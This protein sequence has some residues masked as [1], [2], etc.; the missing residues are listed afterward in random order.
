MDH[1]PFSADASRQGAAYVVSPAGD[2]DMATVP[3]VREAVQ[4]RDREP[5]TDLLVLDLRRVTFMDTSGLQL[6]VEQL[7]RSEQDGHSFAV[8]RGPRAVQRLLDVAG[9]T[10]ALRMVDSPEEAMADDRDH[11]A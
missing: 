7:R 4:R 11:R 5:G 3:I 10:S 9:L 6:L 1:V 8:V 2:L